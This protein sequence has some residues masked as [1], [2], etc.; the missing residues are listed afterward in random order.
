MLSE[1]YGGGPDLASKE[2]NEVD[3]LDLVIILA[4]SPGASAEAIEF[5]N[6]NYISPKLFVFI[7]REYRHGYVY[8][9]LNSSKH[10][11][12]T[13]N[14][15]FSL[16]KARRYDPEIVLKVFAEATDKRLGAV[17]RRRIRR[18]LNT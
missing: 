5:A 6:L 15:L 11:I 1:D 3:A 7:P 18:T 4:A 9:S 13:E 8:R 2:I 16:K 12:V 17:R 14:S 10:R